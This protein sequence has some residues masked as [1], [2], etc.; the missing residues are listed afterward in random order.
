MSIDPLTA[1]FDLGKIA[2]EKIWPDP[3]KRASELRKLEELRQRGDAA[4]INAHV[5]LMVGQMEINSSEAKHKS[6]FVAGWRPFVG[7]TCGLALAYVSLIEPFMRFV[8]T[9]IAD[10]SG[11]FPV[12]DTTITMQV[13]LGMLGLAAAR[14]REKE[15]SVNSDSLK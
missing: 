10:Y 12:I 4:V 13:L 7:W 3:A 6:I 8:A 1:A 15:K 2:I 14:T 11:D 9:V 5:K